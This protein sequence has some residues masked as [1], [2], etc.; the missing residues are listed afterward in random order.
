M[1][2]LFAS[3]GQITGAS[4][5]TSVLPTN[6]VKIDSEGQ[7][8]VADE[9]GPMG[10]QLDQPLIG[11]EAGSPSNAKYNVCFMHGDQS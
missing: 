1:S 7:S 4:A 11:S 2:Q 10:A 6:T 3:V 9:T 8:A 5:S